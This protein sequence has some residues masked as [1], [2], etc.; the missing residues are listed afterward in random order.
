MKTQLLRASLAQQFLLMSFPIVL[1]ATLV[2]GWWTGQQVQDSVLRRLGG[3]AALYV[4]GFIAPHVQTLAQTPELKDSD[5]TALGALLTRTALGKRIVSLKIWRADGRVLFSS[6]GHGMGQT[7]PVDAGLAAALRGE[8]SSEINVRSERERHAHGQPGLPRVIETYTPLHRQGTGVVLAVAEFY[9]APHEL[10]L[11]V[12]AAQTRS[13]LVVAGA[14]GAT[15][16]LL[17]AVVRRG[18]RTIGEQRAALDE[19]VQQ[20][21]ELNQQNTQLH[22]RVGRAAERTLVLNESFL[23]RISADMHDGPGQDLGFALMRLKSLGERIAAAG[24]P[25]SGPEL[26]PVQL[27]V[28][29]AL[30][31]LRAILADLELP[32]IAALGLQEIAE[33]VVRDFT[34][35]TQASVRL[36]CAVASAAQASFPIKVTLYRLLQEALANAWR[37]AA[38]QDCRVDVTADERWLVVKVFDAGPGFDV[39]S[40]VAQQRLGLR[41]MRQRVEMQRGMFELNSRPGDGTSIRVTLP[42]IARDDVED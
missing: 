4:D 27:A 16:L 8:I 3:M 1:A 28:Q 30:S 41:G 18:S 33:R 12:R 2:I 13:W 20:L 6:D 42:L 24:A 10:D 19:Q 29:S 38:C 39:A 40:G 37:H 23:Q 36:R 34:L 17:F 32:D 11:E 9:Q 35:K 25:C 14:M 15:Y 26:E 5:R 31:D 7:F 21:T 22:A